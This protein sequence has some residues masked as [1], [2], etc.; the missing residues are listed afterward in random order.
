MREDDHLLTLSEQGNA[1]RYLF[2]APM[3]QA[4]DRIVEDDR[5]RNPGKPSLCQEVCEGQDLLLSLRQHLRW[6]VLASEHLS[7]LSASLAADEL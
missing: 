4:V 2:D 1:V 7:T 3:I 6:S 5:G